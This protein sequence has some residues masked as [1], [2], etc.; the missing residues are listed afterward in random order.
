MSNSW[1]KEMED[2][3]TELEKTSKNHENILKWNE[4]YPYLN[5]YVS[6]LRD[7]IAEL[8]E[9]HKHQAE[10][11]QIIHE[12]IYRT[13]NNLEKVLRDH[14]ESHKKVA[15]DQ[16]TDKA[17]MDIFKEFDEAIVNQLEKLDGS[18]TEKK[19][20]EK[21]FLDLGMV[22][23][24]NGELLD[25]TP[26]QFIKDYAKEH[27]LFSL[28]GLL[29][30]LEETSECDECGGHL[31]SGYLLHAGDCSHLH[32]KQEPKEK[33]PEQY[34]QGYESEVIAHLKEQ[35]KIE[36]RLPGGKGYEP[37]EDD[38]RN[39]TEDWKEYMRERIKKIFPN[40]DLVKREDLQNWKTLFNLFGYDKVAK[41]IKE[42]YGI[43]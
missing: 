21:K 26:S 8:K 29:F 32:D 30:P 39:W 40:E 13:F 20:A 10:N 19:E 36:D 1:E 31:F 25:Y 23:S 42:A 17:S 9:L 16:L 3:I 15:R 14:F 4:K 34:L 2:K 27:S 28:I 43:D 18:K 5:H 38:E 24:E 22:S 37:R 33:S 11:D 12:E 6:H 7:E 35:G 41:Y